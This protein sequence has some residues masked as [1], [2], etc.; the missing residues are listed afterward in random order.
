MIDEVFKEL[1]NGMERTLKNLA[2]ELAKVRTG[3]ANPAILE[4]IKVPYY[5]TPTPINQMATVSVPEARLIVILPWDANSVIEI[6][7]GI[8]KADIGVNP[9]NDGKVIRIAFPPLTEDRR[10]DLVKRIR[11]MG[12]D[13]KITVRKERRDANE[14][15]KDLEKEKEIS[16]DELHRKQDKVQKVHDDYI[17]KVDEIIKSKET[18]IMEV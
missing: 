5:G 18:E 6:E 4:G 3:R 10:K 15:L 8:Q 9:M 12:E 11:K 7:K 13:C 14:M 1:N 2:W 16:E 17:K